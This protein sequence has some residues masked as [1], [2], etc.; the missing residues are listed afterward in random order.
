[1]EYAIAGSRRTRNSSALVSTLYRFAVNFTGALF[2]NGARHS[3]PESFRFITTTMR[4]RFHRVNNSVERG[5]RC[6]GRFF[7]MRCVERENH[8]GLLWSREE[9]RNA[10]LFEIQFG[11]SKTFSCW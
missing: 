5:A 6:A 2:K 1:M 7:I 11:V 8:R 4:L 3:A 10:G 9:M